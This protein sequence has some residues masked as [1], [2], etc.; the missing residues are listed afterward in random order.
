MTRHTSEYPY[1]QSIRLKEYDYTQSGAYFVTICTRNRDPLF[2]VVVND[3]MVLNGFGQIVQAEWSRTSEVTADVALD[4]FVVM[5]NYLHG[6]LLLD[7]TDPGGLRVG[8]TRRVARTRHPTGLGA[9]TLGA[10][11]GQFKSLATKRINTL[12]GTPGLSAWQRNYYE[13][14]IR[15]E[16][17]LDR[18]REYIVSNPA[19]SSCARSS[20]SP[21][22]EE[23]LG[24]RCSWVP[25]S[26]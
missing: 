18:V 14:V 7:R 12:R 9:S 22:S 13:H 8:A 10:I 15:S 26:S 1:R 5:P 21:S 3:K 4:T 16:A 6:I 20:A 25:W 19:P 23:G 2:G 11:I 17:D 24:C